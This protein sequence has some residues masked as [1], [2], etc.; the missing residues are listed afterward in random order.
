MSN[1]VLSHNEIDDD[2]HFF[3]V[4]CSL[5]PFDLAFKI[6]SLL[7]VKLERANVDVTF[8][9]SKEKYMVYK[10]VVK[11]NERSIWLYSNSFL[12]T[13]INKNP[14]ILFKEDLIER[15]LIPEFSKADYVLKIIGESSFCRKFTRLLT[16]LPEVMSCYILPNNKVKS[17]HNLIFD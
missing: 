5:E 12:I 4:H 9:N 6:N 15:S 16:S 2:G 7:E 1:L 11:K 10:N 8:K 17:K 14:V 3:G 13:S